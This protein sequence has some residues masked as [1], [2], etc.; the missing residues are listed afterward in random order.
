MSHSTIGGCHRSVDNISS[1]NLCVNARGWWIGRVDLRQVLVDQA[2]AFL[3]PRE[4]VRE[5]LVVGLR[6]DDPTFGRCVVDRKG[7]PSPVGAVLSAAV[8]GQAMKQHA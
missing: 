3:Q 8:N 1:S 6:E 5:R 7:S 4:A 2:V